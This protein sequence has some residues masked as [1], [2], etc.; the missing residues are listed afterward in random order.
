MP[1]VIGPVVAENPNA[2]E[3]SHTYLAQINFVQNETKQ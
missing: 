2:R 1:I 3:P